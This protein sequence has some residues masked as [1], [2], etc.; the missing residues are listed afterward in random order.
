MTATPQQQAIIAHDVRRHGR[1]IA[2]P[3]TGKSWTSIALLDRLHKVSPDS[4]PGLLTFTRAATNELV[5]KVETA[6]HDWL[7]PGTIHSFALAL[8]VG[9]PGQVQIPYPVRIPDSWELANL[10][11]PGIASGLR[12]MGFE[13]VTATQVKKLENEMAARWE[14]LD[15]DLVVLADIDPELRNAY[16][17][18][19]GLH[20]SRFGYLL[21]AEL[22][23]RAGDL[24]EDFGIRPENLEFLVVD[25]YQDLNKADIRLVSL[26]A[27]GGVHILAIGDDD[28]SI[29]GFRGAA[30]Q[31][32]RQFHDDFPNASDYSLSV[33]MRCGQRIIDAAMSLIET[34][35]D[36]P[37]RPRLTGV[38]D[39][40]E[41]E[42]VY[43]RFGGHVAEARGVADII[44]ARIAG[45]VDAGE[46]AV[47]VRS[48][49]S[50]W[51]DLLTPHL[52]ER[53][54][55]AVNVD[56]VERALA[57]P[58]LR[59][60]LAVARLVQ[61]RH[62]SL[63]WWTLL[64]LTP[65]IS[66]AFIRYV[67]NTAAEGENFGETLLR[68][69]PGYAGAPTRQS[70]T[71]AQ[72]LVMEQ[73]AA[74]EHV[75]LDRVALGNY[76]WGGWLRLRVEA[77][78]LSED[79]RKLLQDVGQHVPAS[80]GLG[81]F[82]GQLEPIGKDLATHAADVRILSIS[83]SK[84]ITV[85]T[86]LVMGVEA[87]IIPHPRGR[88]DEERRLL[89]VGMTRATRMTVLT[90]AARRTGPTARHGIA[91]INRPRGRCPLLVGLPIGQW[92]DGSD[93]VERFG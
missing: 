15:P 88:L 83:A 71:R 28:Q 35:P 13:G 25:E 92:T 73:L 29:Y 39:A 1:V 37:R 38:D 19:W 46:I 22:P 14:S 34:A 9:H 8:L 82:L 77:G 26:L 21:L 27:V 78:A 67:A 10:I 86:V 76:G 6:G 40:P 23:S 93:Y 16:V 48:R 72:R 87:G 12:A 44:A 65:G 42:F 63:S 3:G 45:G 41:G 53:G 30:P 31:G 61:D 5:R 84:G 24:I 58:G 62:D 81:F 64:K 4:A 74:V 55:T 17:G 70:S 59:R 69:H 57:E 66:D 43:L 49:V 33:S 11:R 50:T 68:L 75:D 2:G 47:L 36:R 20:R 79:A 89:Y 90:A 18:L 51:A 60:A 80:E 7:A 54:I 52:E 56:W 32:L 91:N 85:N